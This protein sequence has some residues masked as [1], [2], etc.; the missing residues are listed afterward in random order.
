MIQTDFFCRERSAEK[1]TVKK[2]H[3][4][5]ENADYSKDKSSFQEKMFFC[6]IA[7]PKAFLF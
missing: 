7:A 3:Y 4:T 1:N 6:D 2:S 5:G